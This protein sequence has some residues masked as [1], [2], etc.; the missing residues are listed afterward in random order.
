MK[1]KFIIKIKDNKFKRVPIPR[2]LREQ[3][4]IKHKKENSRN[5]FYASK[6]TSSHNLEFEPSN[7]L[8]IIV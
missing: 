5:F 8:I 7:L 1:T 6:S 4:W 2:A 3:V